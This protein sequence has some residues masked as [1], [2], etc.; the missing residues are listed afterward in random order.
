MLDVKYQED[1][2]SGHDL[3]KINDANGMNHLNLDGSPINSQN[4][5]T[6]LDVKHEVDKSSNTTSAA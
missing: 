3:K 6:T 2:S 4:A 5:N 1:K